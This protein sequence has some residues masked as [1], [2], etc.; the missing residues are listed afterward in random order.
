MKFV[1]PYIVFHALFMLPFIGDVN[2]TLLWLAG[3]L[4]TAMIYGVDYRLRN[5]GSTLWLYRPAFTL[6]T[7]FVYTWLLPVAMLTIRSRSWR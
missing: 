4:F 2:S 7:T 6:L 3:I 5:P 1:R